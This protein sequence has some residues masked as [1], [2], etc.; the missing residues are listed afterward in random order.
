MREYNR[1]LKSVSRQL[2]SNMTDAEQLLWSRLRRKQL[3]GV[4]FYRQKPLG[5][6]IVD[7]Y[8][9]RANLVVEVDGA[10][11]AEPEHA[12]QDAAR[13]AY[14]NSQGLHVLRFGNHQVLRNLDGVVENVLDKIR[15]Q[16]EESASQFPLPHGDGE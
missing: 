2:R 4:P 6:Y 13:D 11:H 9:P 12:A 10:Q 7:F 3:L 15:F 5:R 1:S 16:L 8:A 14:L